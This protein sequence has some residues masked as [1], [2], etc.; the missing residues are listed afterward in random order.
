[1]RIFT[2]GTGK[3]TEADISKIIS[4]YQIQVLADIRRRSESLRREDVQRLC[5]E[6]K[7]EYIYLGNELGSE[8]EQGILADLDPDLCKRG[9]SILKT[10]AKTRGLLILCTEE[11]PERCNRRP[12][13]SELS[14]EGAEV[15]HLLDV[16]AVWTPASNIRQAQPPG[17]DRRPFSNDQRNSRP[18]GYRRNAGQGGQGRREGREQGGGGG[19]RR[20]P[21]SPGRAGN[22]RDRGQGPA[23]D[24]RGPRPANPEKRG[25]QGGG[26]GGPDFKKRN[27]HSKMDKS[28]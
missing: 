2:L 16:E 4:K 22:Q 10:L 6:A 18:Q 28:F 13:S 23:R 19:G 24:N 20:R 12:I 21:D 25:E 7:A 26:G 14:K 11:T 3:R 8:R 5:K 9:I 17:Q 1:M 27:P 15:I